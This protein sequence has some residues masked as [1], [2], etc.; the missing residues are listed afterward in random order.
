MLR[1]ASVLLYGL[2]VLVGVGGLLTGGVPLVEYA[3]KRLAGNNLD[4]Y[5][6]L[7]ASDRFYSEVTLVL[8]LMLL[9]LVHIGY[10]LTRGSRARKSEKPE[11][12]KER[13]EDG[14]GLPQ[15]EPEKPRSRPGPAQAA[16]ELDQADEK[17]APLMK[18]GKE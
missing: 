17:L 8:S 1:L 6:I 15:P 18:K 16:A 11:A 3:A 4:A 12:I 13:M 14:A 9:I 5:L 7:S 2:A 10:T